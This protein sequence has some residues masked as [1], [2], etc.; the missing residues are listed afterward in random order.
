MS[1]D[2]RLAAPRIA[3]VGG[4]ISGLAAA[5]RLLELAP[6]A[7]VSLIEASER[8]GG[9]LQTTSR[10]G[11]LIEH[12]ADMFTTKEPWA[13]DL[14]RRIGFES[15]LIGVNASHR[16][17]L[18]AHRGRLKKIPAGFSLMSPTRIWPIVT[19]SLLG[20]LGKLRLAREPLIPAR[21]AG[22]DESLADFARR[23]LGRQAYERLVQPIVGGIYTADP[24]RLSM[25]A[26]LPQFVEMEEHHGSVIRAALA[27]RR[28][29]RADRQAS[30]ARYQLFVAPR[31]GMS[32]LVEAL[33]SRI[34][35]TSI[36]L[37]TRV[38]SIERRGSEW[39]LRISG[40]EERAFDALILA[41]GAAEAARLLQA[42][43]PDLARELSA[44]EHASSVV[45]ARGYRRESIAHALD[46]FGAVVPLVE[47][48]K[49]LAISFSSVKF[50]GRAPEGCVLLRIF[51]GGACQPELNEL[52]DEDLSAL[53]DRELAELIGTRG[54]PLFEQFFR[55]RKAMPQYHVGHLDR[56]ARIES[57]VAALPGLKFAGASLR[58]VGIPFCIR[59]GEKAVEAIVN[60]I[61]VGARPPL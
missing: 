5:H 35:A 13:V 38:E 18:V 30:G 33:A 27:D 37:S 50:A 56:V 39:R 11:F 2:S 47:K 15:E 40:R 41:S 46:A 14:C 42:P 1:Q 9:A 19:T 10:D 25:R 23:R 12:G 36:E 49:I 43:A 21:R 48:R 61:A 22:A 16:Q 34:P 31:R 45:V 28:E 60:R 3:V 4:G 6:A 54:E 55:W 51:V 32:S 59:S 29:G 53:I 44:I 52:A 8:L 7:Q 17:A 58:G 26:A 24:E 20:P 57:L